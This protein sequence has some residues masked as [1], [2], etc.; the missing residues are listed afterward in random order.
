LKAFLLAAGHGTRLRPITDAIPKCLV[1]IRGV[2]LLAIW[3][4]LCQQFGIDDVLIN[5]HAHA[6]AV[7]DFLRQNAN[8]VQTRVVEEPELL[9]SAGTLR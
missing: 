9:G 1:P 8:G 4:R 5:V 2:P 3:L 7:Q 6:A